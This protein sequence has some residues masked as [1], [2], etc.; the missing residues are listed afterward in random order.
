MFQRLHQRLH[1]YAY[2]CI[3][4]T[5]N[6]FV[7]IMTYRKFLF[8]LVFGLLST[9]MVTAQTTPE[10]VIIDGEAIPEING[11]YTQAN[12]VKCS[13]IAT[14]CIWEDGT[15]T[16]QFKLMSDGSRLAWSHTNSSDADG[17]YCFFTD[18][19]SSQYFTF[20]GKDGNAEWVVGLLNKT[21]PNIPY[22]LMKNSQGRRYLVLLSHKDF[23]MLTWAILDAAKFNI[24]KMNNVNGEFS[25]IAS[26]LLPKGLLINRVTLK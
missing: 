3:I 26:I 23:V 25:T 10:Q 11:V 15:G 1:F 18:E 24:I 7:Y 13:I 17:T 21:S 20:L 19:D 4:I 16:F 14:R 2:L 9:T 5:I 6:T 12:S 8:L 22:L